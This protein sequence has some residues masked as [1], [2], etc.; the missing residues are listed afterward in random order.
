M[1]GTKRVAAIHDLSCFGRCS[2][3]V[4]LPV[5]SVMGVQC[6]PM[7]TAVLSSHTGGFDHIARTDLTGQMEGTVAQWESLPLT[8][9]GVYTGYMASAEQL[10]LV[11][12]AVDILK[13][14]DG[15]VVVDP[16]LG[17]HGRLYRSITEEMVAAMAELCSH[18]DVITPNL[19]E[20]NLL[21]GRRPDAPIT[22]VENMALALSEEG[23]RSVVI[24]GVTPADGQVGA[25]WYDRERSTFGVAAGQ[26]VDGAYPG[27]GD[28]FAAVLTGGLV[29]GES[30]A[31]SADRAADFVRRCAGR[32]LE[33]ELPV[34]E[35][36]E[37]EPLLGLLAPQK[38][39]I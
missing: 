29:R 24:T 38:E 33:K 28:L 23:R 18:A 8:F 20:A 19:T 14:T 22:D 34:R 13:K 16:V 10:R 36:V 9:D 30:L 6:C 32:T 4:I 15:L 2:L 3:A 7:P 37:F 5:L 21:L 11:C 27:T 25:A 31:R 12:G 17:D 1:N 39:R 26:R 35:G